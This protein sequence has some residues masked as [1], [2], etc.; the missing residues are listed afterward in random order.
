MKIT[1]RYLVQICLLAAMLGAGAAR[2]A[3]LS[4]YGTLARFSWFTN[5]AGQNVEFQAVARDS[6][7]NIYVGGNFSGS[8]LTI[9]SLSV[10]NTFSAVTC[11]FILKVDSAG[12]P[13][14][15]VGQIGRVGYSSIDSIIVDGQDAF[16]YVTGTTTSTGISQNLKIGTCTLCSTTIINTH[17]VGFIYK[18]SGAGVGQNVKVLGTSSVYSEADLNAIASDNSIAVSGKVVGSGTFNGVALSSRTASIT[19][20]YVWVGN[21]NE[22]AKWGV[23][24]TDTNPTPGSTAPY[25]TFNAVTFDS[26]TNVIAVGSFIGNA[27][28]NDLQSP[29]L[30]SGLVAKW[31]SSGNLLWDAALQGTNLAGTYADCVAVDAADNIYIGGRTSWNNPASPATLAIQG[32]TPGVSAS[33]PLLGAVDGYLAKLNSAG[34]PQWITGAG[35]AGAAVAGYANFHRLAIAGTNVYVGGLEG[36]SNAAAIL[37]GGK[38]PVLESNAGFV[39]AFSTNDGSVTWVKTLPQGTPTPLDLTPQ[40]LAVQTN[41]DVLLAGM[42]NSSAGSAADSYVATVSA[43]Q[44]NQW[45]WVFISASNQLP[46]MTWYG[47]GTLVA[48]T[49][50]ASPAWQVVV[51]NWPATNNQYQFT[52]GSVTNTPKRFFRQSVP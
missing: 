35:G 40:G 37:F 16:I 48:A 14:W 39:A 20:G 10:T 31:D 23:T 1:N 21:F 12:N 28:T 17:T 32:Q 33:Y 2:G 13:L 4:V 7:G 43:T 42:Q 18:Y 22:V 51:T 6:A 5:T 25:V 36:L 49:S 38:I 27:M 3:G 29:D 44:S 47:S 26:A 24:S 19:D 15:L 34:D 11:A 46:T 50:L 41:G 9:G 8:V 52:D 30:Y 45:P